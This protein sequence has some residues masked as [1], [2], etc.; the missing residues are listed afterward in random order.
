MRNKYFD[1]RYKSKPIAD[2]NFRIICQKI[3]QNKS[4]PPKIMR[5][6][7]IMFID[8][9]RYTHSGPPHHY[10]VAAEGRST[11]SQSEVEPRNCPL[12]DTPRFADPV[13][14]I[15]IWFVHFYSFIRSVGHRLFLNRSH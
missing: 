3:E 11:A 9:N 2:R 4:Y 12:E 7:Y 13:I 15:V 10:P 1:N 6:S 8:I 5:I 14:H